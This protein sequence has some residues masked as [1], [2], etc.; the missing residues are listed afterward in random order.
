MRHP[1]PMDHAMD[2]TGAPTQL[3]ISEA[4]KTLTVA[5]PAPNG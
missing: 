2:A 1:N 3:K 5:A 4:K